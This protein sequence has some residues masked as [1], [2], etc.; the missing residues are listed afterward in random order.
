MNPE[1][2]ERKEQFYRVV[3]ERNGRYFRNSFM[4]DGPL[5]SR[6]TVK[7]ATKLA[8]GPNDKVFKVIETIQQIK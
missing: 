6:I 5:E 2:K 7:E 3:I 1:R 4:I 8:T